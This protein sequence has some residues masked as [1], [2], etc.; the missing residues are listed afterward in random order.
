MAQPKM[1]RDQDRGLPHPSES[2]SL[3]VPTRNPNRKPRPLL[4]QSPDGWI[5]I[6]GR[7]DSHGQPWSMSSGRQPDDLLPPLQRWFNETTSA[8]PWLGISAI[9][10]VSRPKQYTGHNRLAI[11]S[12]VLPTVSEEN[13]G[14]TQPSDGGPETVQDHSSTVYLVS[15]AQVWIFPGLTLQS[16]FLTLER[17]GVVLCW[18]FTSCSPV[19]S[20]QQLL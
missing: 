15:K 8:Q 7:R 4:E 18:R 16:F 3:V 9:R 17:L 2:R 5:R 20:L 10:V 1:G 11:R 12:P 14:M 6:P 13:T 19:T